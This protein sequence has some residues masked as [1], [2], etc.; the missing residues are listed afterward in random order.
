[1]SDTGNAAAE[2]G[3]KKPTEPPRVPSWA[4]SMSVVHS[5]LTPGRPRCDGRKA[6]SIQHIGYT[7]QAVACVQLQHQR[8]SGLW[9]EKWAK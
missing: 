3:S 9:T 8:A 2:V 7:K 4:Y 5:K 1:M 6:Q